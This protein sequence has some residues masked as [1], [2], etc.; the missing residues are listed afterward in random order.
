ML[1]KNNS[2]NFRIELAVVSSII[3][4]FILSVGLGFLFSSVSLVFL[5]IGVPVFLFGIIGL[6]SELVNGKK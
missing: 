2:Q 5:L 3:G 1:P 6:Y 4:W